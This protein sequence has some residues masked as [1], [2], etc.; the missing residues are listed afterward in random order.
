MDALL[1][2]VGWQAADT[3]LPDSPRVVL[4]FDGETTWTAIYQNGRW[5]NAQAEDEELDVH[6]THWQEMPEPPEEI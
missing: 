2:S 1:V 5:F 6:I 3:Y 4:A